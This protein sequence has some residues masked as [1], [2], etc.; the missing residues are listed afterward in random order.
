MIGIRSSRLSRRGASM[1][2]F[3]F[4]APIFFT[5]VMG[6][7][8][9]GRACMVT[10]QLTEAARRACRAGI[11]EG[12]SGST[13]QSAA[14]NYLTSMGISGESASV[15]VNDVLVGSSTDVS[16]MPAYTEITVAVTVPFSSVAWMTPSFVTANLSGQYTMRRE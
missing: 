5:T 15:Y 14:T 8:E 13:I 6:L 16:S 4:I 9:I 10:E 3:A 7:I 1:V 11:I 12:T 2:E